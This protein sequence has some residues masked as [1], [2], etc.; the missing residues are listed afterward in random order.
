VNT[1]QSPE[2][3]D[4]DDLMVVE[5]RRHIN[6]DVSSES[7]KARRVGKERSTHPQHVQHQTRHG[8]SKQKNTPGSTAVTITLH[9]EIVISNKT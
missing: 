7:R 4:R 2:K 1:A 6:T 8:C 9:S 3:S 5:K